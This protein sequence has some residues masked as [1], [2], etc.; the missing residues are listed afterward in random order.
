MT[1][2]RSRLTGKTISISCQ[3]IR[4]GISRRS[5]MPLW[6]IISTPVPDV[7]RRAMPCARRAI[8]K[9]QARPSTLTAATDGTVAR[10]AA[11]KLAH[12][13]KSAAKRSFAMIHEKQ[14]GGLVPGIISNQWDAS[15]GPMAP[16]WAKDKGM[17]HGSSV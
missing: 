17:L 7:A 10:I 13:S 16:V 12:T 8:A 1:L 15:V 2:P 14:A 4:L 9:S 3:P 5:S 6:S 11:G